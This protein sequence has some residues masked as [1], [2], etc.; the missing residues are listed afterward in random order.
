MFNIFYETTITSLLKFTAKIILI[1]FNK[2]K[3]KYLK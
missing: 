3:L 1:I 2:L